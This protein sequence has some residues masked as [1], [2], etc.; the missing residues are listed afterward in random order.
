M[1]GGVRDNLPRV[2]FR[3]FAAASGLVFAILASSCL[4]YG[5]DLLATGGGGGTGGGTGGTGASTATSSSSGTPC[6]VAEDCPDPGSPCKTRVCNNSVCEVQNAP[7]NTPV[8][9]PKPGDCHGLVC[10]TA[11]GT[12]EVENSK[13]VPDDGEFC[14]F[15]SCELG[16]PAHTPKTGFGCSENG[17]HYCD[18]HGKC[19]ECFMDANCTSKVC[20]AGTCAP[21]G[22]SDGLKNGDETD[23]DCGGSCQGCATGK[24]CKMGTDCLSQICTASV[25]K[26]SCTDA[27]KNNAE[28]DVD[29]GGGTC[30]ACDD[31]KSCANASDCKSQV[32]AGGK[33]QAPTCADGKKNGAEIGVDCGGPCPSCLLDHIVINE[34]D[35]DQLGADTA[36]LVEI[37]NA[38]AA[39]VLLTNHK[40]VLIDGVSNAPYGVVDLAPAGTLG[41]GQY[42]LVMDSAVMAPPNAIKVAFPSGDM[43]SLQNGLVGGMGSPDGLA[44]IDDVK[45]VVID[46]FSYEGAITTADLSMWGLGTVS[47]VEGVALSANVLDEGAGSLCRYPNSKDTG[48]A[49]SDWALCSAPT[50]GALNQK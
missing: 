28:T 10:D 42:L 45:K 44:L 35:Y 25:C 48:N 17:G 29:C 36:E 26:P 13:D 6:T 30:P 37:Y 12:I 1:S 4:I 50:P 39:P 5:E 3:G 21:A 11:G 16:L 34:V 20:K 23:T 14:T 2:R 41:P 7:P 49:A 31:G 24:A 38:T 46:V 9:D 22:C 43:N 47:L 18:D 19:V 15:D 8:K 32:C 33:C 40:L 27:Q